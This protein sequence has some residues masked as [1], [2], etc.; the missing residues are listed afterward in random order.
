[1]EP[2]RIGGEEYSSTVIARNRSAARY[3]YLRRLKDCCWTVLD[4]ADYVDVGFKHI[5]VRRC[6]GISMAKL[7]E[8][9]NTAE[10][11]GVPLARLGMVVEVGGRR[12]VIIDSTDSANFEVLFDD[13]SKGACHP[14][15]E[16]VYFGSG[17]EILADFRQPRR[18][19]GGNHGKTA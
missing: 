3:E 17:G 7:A 14:N 16:M 8:F 15:W 18:D 2:C 6:G 13:G 5:R 12:G 19:Q 1:M 11:R 10:R 4:G 9:A